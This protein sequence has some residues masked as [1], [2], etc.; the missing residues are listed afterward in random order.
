M[1]R[2]HPPQRLDDRFSDGLHSAWQVSEVG[3]GQVTADAGTLRLTNRPHAGYS[4]AQIADYGADCDFVWRPPLRLTVRAQASAPA[5]DLRGTAGFGFWNHP[6]SPD[7]RRLPRL[8]QAIWFFFSSPPS[9]MRLAQGVPGPGWKAA[10]IDATTPRALLWAPLAPPI[11]LLNRWPRF[12]RAVWPRVQRALRIS[13][14][15]LDGVLLAEPH[16]YALE[17]HADGARFAVDGTIIHETADAPRGPAGFVA[18]IDNQY[19]V[20]TPEGQFAFG[21]TPILREQSLLL[22]QVTIER[23]V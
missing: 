4:N 15:L 19:A 10:T 17:W 8:P 21:I 14:R 2:Q 20:V 18:W 6:F 7:R 9:S 11:V 1:N 16:T 3:G 5:A 13:E 22:T 12:Y 23:G